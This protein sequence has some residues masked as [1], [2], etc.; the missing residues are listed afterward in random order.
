[1][2]RSEFKELVKPAHTAVVVVDFQ[3]VWCHN[4]G[5]LAKSGRDVS[6]CQ[7]AAY[8]CE[9]FLKEVRK[10]NV[11]VIFT[12]CSHDPWSYS[13]PWL[14]KCEEMELPLPTLCQKG[15]WEEEFFVVSPQRGEAV[16]RKR[17]Y[18]AFMDTDLDLILRSQGIKTI[19][20]TGVATE[21]CVESTVR[22]AYQMD[23][24]VVL[25]SDCTGSPTL[26]G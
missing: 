24:E 23:Y 12:Q 3:N 6:L 17:R 19:I 15:S 25:L 18:S 10:K 5:A 1:M 20:V 2:T 7:K 26:K 21:V 9:Q 11:R 4:D 13:P 22:D 8:N 14:R 16:V